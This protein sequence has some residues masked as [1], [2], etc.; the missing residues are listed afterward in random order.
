MNVAKI[1]H[2]VASSDESFDDAIHNGVRDAAKSLRGI[3]GIK[4]TDWTASVQDDQV[5]QYKVTMDVAFA[6]EE[7]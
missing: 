3:S 4:I 1:I 5:T 7:G 2:I 6:V